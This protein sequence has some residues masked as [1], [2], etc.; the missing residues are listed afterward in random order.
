MDRYVD[1]GEWKSK[2]IATLI[3]GMDVVVLYSHFSRY[4]VPG[5]A[6]DTRGPADETCW[7]SLLR[8]DTQRS[9]FHR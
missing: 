3:E 5:R 6:T 7:Y 2:E 8:F 1:V 4:R 9:P